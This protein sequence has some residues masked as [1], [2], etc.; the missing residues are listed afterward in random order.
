MSVFDS[1]GVALYNVR[2]R[3]KE[4]PIVPFLEDLMRRR[5]RL[6]SQL[7]ADMGISHAA[8]SRWL[9]GKDVPS[10]R[11]CR[12]LAEYSNMFLLEILPLA[13]YMPQIAEQESANWPEFREYARKKYPA[14]LDDDLITMFEDLIERRRA[15]GYG[16]KDPKMGI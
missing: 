9:S 1:D 14:E 8:V 6:P 15:R 16:G 10:T 4:V 2:M 11:S 5:K 7:A 3:N 13:G 12:K